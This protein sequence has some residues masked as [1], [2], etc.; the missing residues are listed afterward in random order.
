MPRA[1]IN[2]NDEGMSF[3]QELPKDILPCPDI[4]N[5]K[6]FFDQIK[7]RFDLKFDLNDKDKTYFSLS[8]GLNR[9]KILSWLREIFA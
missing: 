6:H 7:S 9:A 8:K 2:F 1:R 5:L 3:L 4:L